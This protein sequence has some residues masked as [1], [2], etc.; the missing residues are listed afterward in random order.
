MKKICVIIPYFGK[1][2]C[3]FNFWLH[4]ALN[5]PT[6]DFLLF[7]DCNIKSQNNIKIIPFTFKELKS[8]LQNN[9]DFQITLT[10]PYKL[11]DYRGAY[12]YIFQK[13]ISEYD[14]WG[15]GDIDL[16]YGDIRS[17]ITDDVLDKYDIISGWGHLTFYRNDQFCNEFFM[18]KVDGFLYYKDVFQCERNC[19]FDEY[20]HKGLSDLWLHLYP[21]KILRGGVERHI[22]DVTIPISCLHF[23][24]NLNPGISKCLIFEYFDKHLYRVYIGRDGNVHKES[25][26][27]AHF[28]KRPF[29]APKTNDFEHYLI[30]PNRIIK[31]KDLSIKTVKRLGHSLETKRKIRNFKNRQINRLKNLLKYI[32]NR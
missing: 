19:W 5:N 17:F 32:S 6:I 3:I 12:G 31:N 28:Q 25:I 18:N 22:D 11:C 13:Y 14:F 2:P 1:L 7:T 21:E 24:S 16:V 29:L 10:K 23:H 9:F 15:F 20:L 8:Y 30:V 4:S 27:Y 26:L